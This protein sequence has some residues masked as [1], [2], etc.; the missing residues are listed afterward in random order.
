VTVND[1][2]IAATALAHDVP[3][4]SQDSDHAVL[5]AISDLQVVLV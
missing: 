4:V 2:W 5:A 3:L 1:T